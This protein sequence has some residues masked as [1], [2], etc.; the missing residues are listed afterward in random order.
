M[1]Q[2]HKYE[3]Q[4]SVWPSSLEQL[5]SF[6]PELVDWAKDAWGEGDNVWGRYVTLITYDKSLGYGEVVSYGRDGKPGGT[7]LDSDLVVRFPTEANADW[8]KRQGAGLKQPHFR[9]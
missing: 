1:Q 2:S 6:R 8:N 9:Q 3:A 7:G 5:R 4:Y